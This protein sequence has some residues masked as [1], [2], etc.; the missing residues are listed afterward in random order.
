MGDNRGNSQ[1]SR[2]LGPVDQDKIVGKAF[3]IIWPA[4]DFGTI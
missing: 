3:V 4:G 2:Y 1:D